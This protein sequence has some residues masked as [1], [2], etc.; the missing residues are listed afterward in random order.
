MAEQ[1]LP[2]TQRLQ[3]I[4]LA[5]HRE[6]EGEYGCPGVACPGVQRLAAIFQRLIGHGMREDIARAKG[7]K[8]FDAPDWQPIATAPK[9]GTSVLLSDGEQVSYG[10]WISAA[11]QGAEP[12]EEHLIAAGWWS[13]DLSDNEPTFWMPL[14]QGPTP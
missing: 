9:D 3:E 4:A 14:P 1:I 6:I 7:L 11:D 13:V 12:G 5:F 8:P 10:G 2:E